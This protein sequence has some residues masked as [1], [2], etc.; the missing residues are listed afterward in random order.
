MT[1]DYDRIA[2]T[3]T[4]M[5]TRY[6]RAVTL[7]SSGGDTYDPATATREVYQT[8]YAT[9]GLMLDYQ[10]S[11]IDGTLIQVGDQK[12]YMEPSV[13]VAPKTGDEILINDVV[14]KVIKSRPVSPAGVVVLHELQVRGGP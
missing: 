8:E 13:E 7:R 1:F 9:I 5:L 11:D 2:A 10:Q 3:A 6:G 4:R 14:F 12:V